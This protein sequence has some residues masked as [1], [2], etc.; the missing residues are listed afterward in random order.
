MGGGEQ[1]EGED[2]WHFWELTGR[3][4]GGESFIPLRSADCAGGFFVLATHGDFP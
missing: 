1:G 3:G 2:G 4:G